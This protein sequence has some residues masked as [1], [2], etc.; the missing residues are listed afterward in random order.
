MPYG[1]DK[2]I[3]GDSPEN[4]AWMEKCVSRVMKTGK[5]KGAAIA[6]C[7]T[8]LKKTKGNHSDASFDISLY[9]WNE[10]NNK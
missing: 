4:D 6:I 1:V 9:L 5:E 3:G 7:K 2:D 10:L 8:T